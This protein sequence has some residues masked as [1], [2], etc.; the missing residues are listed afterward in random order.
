LAAADRRPGK[1]PRAKNTFFLAGFRTGPEAL[2]T[3]EL[4]DPG[5]SFKAQRSE[6]NVTCI[7]EVSMYYAALRDWEK[8]A[9]ANSRQ[10]CFI[11]FMNCFWSGDVHG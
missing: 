6:K 4:S 3:R 10:P 7:A 9:S 5:K 2:G 8:V 1:R 11:C